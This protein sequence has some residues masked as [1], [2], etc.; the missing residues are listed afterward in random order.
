MRKI[1]SARKK[2]TS[3]SFLKK[4]YHCLIKIRRFEERIVQ[5]YPKQEI[6]CPV[7]LCIGQEA[8]AAG[9]CLNLERKD[10]I[11]SNHRNH[12]HLIAKGASLKEM[13]AELY[14]RK[15]GCCEGK[16]GSMHMIALEIGILGTSAIV[17]G[18]IPIA[19]GAAFA[20]KFKGA[21]NVAVVFFGDGAVDEGT[22]YEC[23]N[24]ASLK[25]LPLV[26]VCE[27]NFYATNSHQAKRQANTRIHKI[28]EFFL[29]PSACIDGNNVFSVLE[30]SSEAIER[31]RQGLGPSFIEAR[32]YRWK[33]HVGPE[34]DVEKGFR[35]AEEVSSWM[36]NC[37]IERFL[38]EPAIGAGLPKDE[39][40]RI[41]KNVLKEID[42]ALRYALKSPYP[43]ESDLY[44][45]VY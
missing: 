2:F 31:A 41:E 8:I 35:D 40:E 39:L 14:G 32:T 27:N 44:K 37:P 7:H 19:L 38:K 16:G 12:G 42:E 1:K 17:A 11:A 5:L 18:A 25:K 30:A 36:K 13:F 9:V 22:F 15:S 4:I 45:N 24:F 43:I 29:M 3:T 21:K 34:S 33:T 23:L 20:S 6:R 10:F 26:F 28:A